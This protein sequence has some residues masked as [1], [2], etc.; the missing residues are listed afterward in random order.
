MTHVETELIKQ[1]STELSQ[2]HID[3][4]HFLVQTCFHCDKKMELIEGDVIYGDKW[5]HGSCW[6]TI[7]K[8]NLKNV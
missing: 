7:K 5:F 4:D 8:E 1:P 6:K 3:T 2:F